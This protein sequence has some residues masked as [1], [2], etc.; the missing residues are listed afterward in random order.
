MHKGYEW[1]KFI[2]NV[3]GCMLPS[4][5][6]IQKPNIDA[7]QANSTMYRY[8]RFI[9]VNIYVGGYQPLPIEVVMDY[10]QVLSKAQGVY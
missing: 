6:H 4:P 10:A 7:N 8:P 2:T 5:R 9:Y 1:H 3:K